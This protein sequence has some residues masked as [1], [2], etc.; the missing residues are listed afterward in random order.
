[1]DSNELEALR[2]ENATLRKELEKAKFFA[3]IYREE[4]YKRY[5]EQHPY[6]PPTEEELRE[7]MTPDEGESIHAI[8]AELK[9]EAQS[10]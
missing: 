9:S 8:I 10:F 6:V 1:M 2:A 5:N 3:E 4:A 7:L